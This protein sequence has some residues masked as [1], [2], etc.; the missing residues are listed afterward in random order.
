M[1]Y[2]QTMK[3]N[4]EIPSTLHSVNNW[5]SYITAHDLHN[6]PKISEWYRVNVRGIVG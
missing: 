1:K 2:Q 6:V 4:S 5:K 3:P